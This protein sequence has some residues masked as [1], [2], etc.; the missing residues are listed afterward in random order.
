MKIVI[1]D[2]ATAQPDHYKK[3]WMMVGLHE[4]HTPHPDM[5]FIVSNDPAW[6]PF[7][8]GIHFGSYFPVAS[9][10]VVAYDW[11]L[12]FA[13]EFE[14]I[15]RRRWSFMT[16]LYICIRYI[17]ILFSLAYVLFSTPV[18][19]TD[20]VGN[21]SYFIWI[22]APVVANAILGAIMMTRIHAMYGRSSKM[23]IF[24]AALL[25]VS[26]I[27]AGVVAIIGNLGYSGGEAVLSGYH[28]CLYSLD[29][30]GLDLSYFMIIP[31]AIWEILAFF[32]AVR[33]AIKRLR[34][35]RQS[36]SGSTIG[37]YFTVLM[38]S[39]MLYFL[40]FVVAACFYL[41]KLSP[42]ITYSTDFG[43]DVYHGIIGIAQEFQMCI[44]GPRLILSVREYNAKPVASSDP[45]THMTSIAF[46]A[47]GGV[48]T[49]GVAL[50]TI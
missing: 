16:V 24:L 29:A 21:I 46:Q 36:Q 39:H 28:A 32:L 42:N 11:A 4:L 49:D 30:N 33:I 48:S 18:P 44:L 47:G 34:E 6:W 15:W 45:G 20:I 50:E 17:G 27:S 43:G 38:Q 13:Q 12:T 10:A 31:T 25:L 23:L 1:R 8:S 19:M 40:A 22:F 5:A 37:D 3:R 9:F 41:G 26:T 35:L 7:L 14:L 2:T